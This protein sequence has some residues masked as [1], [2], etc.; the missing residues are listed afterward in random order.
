MLKKGVRKSARSASHGAATAGISVLAVA[1]AGCS[2]FPSLHWPWRHK[3]APPPEV[4]ELLE[5]NDAGAPASFPQ[6]WMRNTLVVDLRG[7]TGSGGIVL[8]P[9]E[10]V[11][12]PVRL[13]FKVMPGSIGVLEV[14]AQ[15]RMVLPVTTE[16]TKPIVLELSP[17]VYTPK[18]VQITVSWGPSNTG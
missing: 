9:R 6:Y 8:K 5:T 18:S 15:Q 12:W 4:H 14:R 7:A 16:G 2:H 10:G 17:G 1:L 3:P 13:A 11:T